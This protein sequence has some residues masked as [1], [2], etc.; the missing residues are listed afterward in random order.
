[1]SEEIYAF[2]LRYSRSPRRTLNCYEHELPLPAAEAGCE[3]KL[4]AREDDKPIEAASSLVL[5]GSGWISPEDAQSNGRVYADILA[6][7]C[8]RLRLGAD[9]GERTARK[10][11]FTKEGLEAISQQ[12]GRIILNDVHGLMVYEQT[13]HPKLAFASLK[14]DVVVGLPLEQFL[15]VFELALSRPRELAEQERAAQLLFNASFF[16]DSP[17]ARFMLLMMA[18]EALIEQQPRSSAVENIVLGFMTEVNAA[19]DLSKEEKDTLKSGLGYLKKESIRQAGRRLVREKLSSRSYRGITAE[20]FFENC[21]GLRSS[22]A[23]G[24]LPLPTRDEV[25]GAAG[26]LE[27]MLSDLLSTDL[28]DVGPQR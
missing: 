25:E 8:A 24:D 1:M 5:H 14:G 4:K 15:S 7:T 6:R 27:V 19:A 20:E 23:H 26:Q 21:Y 17:D 10:S 13:S 22:L 28:L 12:A 11:W 3:I 18:L 9:F 16:P 2:R